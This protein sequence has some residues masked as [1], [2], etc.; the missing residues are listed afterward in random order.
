MIREMRWVSNGECAGATDGLEK[1]D[2]SD[3]EI[4]GRSLVEKVEAWDGCECGG[5]YIWRALGEWR[6]WLRES[7]GYGPMMD[8][9]LGCF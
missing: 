1:V 9:I 3:V 4:D 5:T 7:K 6:L 2:E 8:D